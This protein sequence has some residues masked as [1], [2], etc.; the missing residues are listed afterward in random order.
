MVL[1]S[2]QRQDI[3]AS[4]AALSIAATGF[5]IGAALDRHHVRRGMLT[6]IG[7]ALAGGATAIAYTLGEKAQKYGKV[8]ED[9]EYEKFREFHRADFKRWFVAL[10]PEVQAESF[11]AAMEGMGNLLEL[12][13]GEESGLELYN[14]ESVRTEACGLLICGNSG[15]GKTSI[16]KLIAGILT[17]Q[18]PALVL[19]CDPHANRNR[20]EESGLQP[21][22]DYKQIEQTLYWA[23]SELNR[24][25]E[26]GAEPGQRFI[27]ILDELG[28]CFD[29]FEDVP[30]IK[31]IIRQ[32]GTRPR[33]YDACAIILNHSDNCEAIGLDA[34]YRDNYLQIS[35]GALA[36]KRFKQNTPE[37]AY[38]QSQAYPCAVGGPR[39]WVCAK[40]PT[41]GDY[42]EFKTEG[43]PPLVTLP[44]NQIKAMA[45]TTSGEN[46]QEINL[47]KSPQNEGKIQNL[48]PLD[49]LEKAYTKPI[50]LSEA[51]EKL[52]LIAAQYGSIHGRD[53]MRALHLDNMDQVRGLFAKWEECGIG[54]SFP[55]ERGSIE[56]IVVAEEDE[57]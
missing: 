31:R 20:W 5:G 47:K 43:L 24:R 7:A 50:A 44:I 46:P 34:K 51:E 42:S 57:K 1:T 37:Y 48:N 52:L 13:P 38:L 39:P 33:K 32:L 18:K 6:G 40:H 4:I 10:N 27:L 19:V 53:V 12:P 14:W 9:S 56:F 8:E 22:H 49:A 35:L 41:H 23:E 26:P 29:Y 11:L 36:R 17:N 3:Y 28:E 16:A 55:T 45:P 2:Q 30:R 54:R 21:I 25:R 15:Q